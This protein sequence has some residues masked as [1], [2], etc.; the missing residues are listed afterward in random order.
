MLGDSSPDN[1]I[2]SSSTNGKRH[3]KL[4]LFLACIWGNWDTAREVSFQGQ[5]QQGFKHRILQLPILHI[6]YNLLILQMLSLKMI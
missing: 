1:H 5:A 3:K 2:S 4:L 6:V